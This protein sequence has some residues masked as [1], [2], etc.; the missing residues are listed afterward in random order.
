M[1]PYASISAAR[2]TACRKTCNNDNK[3]NVRVD[4]LVVALTVVL[5]EFQTENF[6]TT[7]GRHD[8]RPGKVV[9]QI[10]LRSKNIE[11][12]PSISSHMYLLCVDTFGLLLEN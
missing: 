10:I 9:K 11:F 8:Y 7:S 1:D 3:G 4:K 5:I 2:K 6:F 12:V